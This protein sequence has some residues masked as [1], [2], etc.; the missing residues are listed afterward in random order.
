M[1]IEKLKAKIESKT[2]ARNKLLK[3]AEIYSADIKKM[4]VQ[5]ELYENF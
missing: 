5:L 2:I 1:R 3:K 4:K